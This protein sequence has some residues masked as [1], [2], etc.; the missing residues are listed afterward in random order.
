MSYHSLLGGIFMAEPVPAY[1]MVPL[2]AF[3]AY[4]QASLQSLDL[5][6]SGNFRAYGYR[7]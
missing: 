1:A 3:L 5:E 4:L 6:V 2:K 7:R